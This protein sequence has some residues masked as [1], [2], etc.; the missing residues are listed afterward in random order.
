M[1]DR[2]CTL[3]F[4]F[5][6][7]ETKEDLAS[8]LQ[9][10][11]QIG[12]HRIIASYETKGMEQARFDETYF[13][14]LDRLVGACK[15][16]EV[17]FWL[18]D[19]APFPT[20]SANGAYQEE[21]NAKLNKLFIDERHVDVVGPLA[22]AVLRIDQLQDVI[23]GKAMHR[24]SKVDPSCRQRIGIVAYRTLENPE[25]AAAPFLDEETA[26]LLDDYVE[27]GFLK[28]DV[29]AGAWRV[30]VLFE[31]YESG[32]RV[33]FMNL[34]GKD[35]V[36]LEI[37][38]VHVPLYEHLKGEL[39][40]SWIGFFYD[41]PEVGNDGGD[42]VFD[43]FMLP[44]N[45][46]REMTDCEVLSWSPE[47]RGEMGKRNPDWVKLLPC[48]WYDGTKDYRD[49]R[50]QYMDAVSA[51]VRENYNGQV[52][53]FCKE[54]GIRYIGHV[55]EDENCHTRLGCGPSHYFR[56]QYYQDE[57]GIDVIAGQILPGKDRGMSWYGVP[58]ADGE[59]Y[60]YG[61]AKLASSEAH[62]NP[63]KKNR[64][65]T[66]CFAMYGQQGLAERKFLLD[67]LMV[68]GIN[69]LLFADLPS[70]QAS[71]EYSEAIVNYAER[72]CH[73]LVDAKPVTKTAI[74]YHAENEWREGAKAQKFQRA[75]AVLA[76]NQIS[77]D[78]IPAD[79]FTFPER[80]GAD[81]E[82]GLRVNGNAYE[83]LVVP[84]CEKLPKA[85][86]EFVRR[87][88][89]N[90]F[91]VFFVEHSPSNLANLSGGVEGVPDRTGHVSQADGILNVRTCTLPELAK[92]VREAI[93]P[94]IDVEAEGKEWMRY[95]HVRQG[96]DA[97][98]L[99]H[100]EAPGA[101][102][103]CQVAVAAD[104]DVFEWDAMADRVLRPKQEKVADGRVRV[105]L[106]F[107]RYE[108]KILFV[109]AKTEAQWLLPCAR[110]GL[111]GQAVRITKERP[112]ANA[113]EVEFPDGRKLQG[114]AG[115]L[116]RPEEQVGHG[117]YGKLSY[118]TTLAIEGSPM[119]GFERKTAGGLENESRED[120]PDFL[121]LGG[122]SDCCEVFANGK[123]VGKRPA[124]PY[125]Y[126]VRGHLRQ[127]ENV[128]EAVVYTSAGNQKS[129]A[130]I[131]GV[132][133]DALT[134][135]PYMPVEPLGIRG[136]VRWLS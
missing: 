122:V 136:P 32:G 99:L 23:Y 113:W 29:P 120:V 1:D 47:M 31:T 26:V 68:N 89:E 56:Q 128:I 11:K 84:A 34:L 40:K 121:D 88:A 78:V 69:R 12:F 59:F 107:G 82:K 9:E 131:F 52:Y 112:H 41:E 126:D 43:F 64:A 75:G 7:G 25:S 6:A 133:L 20:G 8:R 91:P 62:I 42:S 38:K 50:C 123:S 77:Y 115:T 95:S 98:Y 39:G 73:L 70:Y 60:H 85:V 96:G 130:K 22:G 44:G 53:A 117:F 51:L 132:P 93:V 27:D 81:L 10:A 119:G 135:V 87:C 33:A 49:F 55:L 57:A 118:K 104:G 94:D 58:N 114:Q 106:S 111:S 100:N 28:W 16:Q 45:R 109:P 5:S 72:V 76:R 4:H 101:G 102:M 21:A 24:F 30:F 17:K 127:G 103:E 63:L 108:M 65:V 124:A 110:A 105:S 54:R 37:E 46:S 13:A 3:F 19:Y 79:V 18:E 2:Q 129:P 15:E 116:P 97:Y 35:S 86:E 61:L 83:A 14:A 134:A 92:A 71:P 80:Y 36:A 74:L 67:H 125:R 90:G 66:E 48:L